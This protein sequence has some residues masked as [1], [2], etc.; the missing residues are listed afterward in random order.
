[1]DR[2]I[3]GLL[4]FIAVAG[5][6][7]LGYLQRWN[8]YDH[9]QLYNY[10]PPNAITQLAEQTTMTPYAKR[11]FYSYHPALEDSASFNR[12]CRVSERAIVL[13]CTVIW[14]GIYLYNTKDP[15][16]DGIQQ[17]TAA[18]EMLHVAYSR[19]SSSERQ[20]INKLV[21]DEYARIKGN[22]PVLVREIQSYRDTEG[23]TA[24]DN[25]L[26]S[27]LGTEVSQLPPELEQY[28]SQYF[29][30]RQ[31]IIKYKERYQEVFSSRQAAV[32]RD[33]QQLTATQKIIN[34]NEAQL[35]QQ[36]QAITR[37]RATLDQKLANNDIAG[38]NAGVAPFNQAIAN[39]NQ[40]ANQTKQLINDYNQLLKERNALALEI[41][42]LTQTISSQPIPAPST[43]SPQ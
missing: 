23:E 22:N 34:S 4:I 18:H 33:D 40:L 31:A 1:M 21:S 27:M 7:G 15:Q 10:Q 3:K 8:I 9:W 35:Q 19:L 39:Y 37:Q 24:I 6:A 28:Y 20:H 16:L 5:L 11:L 36:A 14:R 17:V 41:N 13:G 2:R 29:N 38:Y 30:D 32:E 42:Q 26:H 25:E 43:A 12:D